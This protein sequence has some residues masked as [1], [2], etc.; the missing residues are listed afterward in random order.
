MTSHPF[1]HA[2]EPHVPQRAG[3]AR[4]FVLGATVSASNGVCG[5]LRRVIVDPDT[6]VVT[7]LVVGARHHR[8]GGH[9]VPIGLVESAWDDVMLRCDLADIADLADAELTEV[10]PGPTGGWAGMA[11]MGVDTRVQVVVSDRVPFG[12]V[13]ISTG[14]A[15]F[16]TDGAVGHVGGLISRPDDE[17]ITHVLLEQGHL[18]GRREVWVPIAAVARVENGVHLSLSQDDV[19]QLPAQTTRPA[20]HDRPGTDPHAPIVLDIL[21]TTMTALPRD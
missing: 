13:E 14:D 21:A 9:L 5:E 4:Q 8:T 7:H 1:A 15:V 2:T 17:H 16:A 20:R 18:W 6:L 19:R 10:F 11:A 3:S 12:E